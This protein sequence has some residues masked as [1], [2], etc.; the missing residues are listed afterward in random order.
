MQEDLSKDAPEP[1]RRK[2]TVHSL[3]GMKKAGER[4]AALT[5]Y[6]Y[7]MAVLLDEAGVDVIL[8]GD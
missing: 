5:A 1:A 8:A 4:I 3:R 2:V 6:D 7:L